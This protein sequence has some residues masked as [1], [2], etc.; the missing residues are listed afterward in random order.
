[1]NVQVEEWWN[2][3]RQGKQWIQQASAANWRN[4][5]IQESTIY[6]L[7][8]GHVSTVIKKDSLVNN[9]IIYSIGI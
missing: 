3:T 8:R 2:K 5:T 9:C 4:H 6:S 1:M 7:R